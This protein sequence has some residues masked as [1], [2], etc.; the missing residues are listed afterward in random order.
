M[1]Y[2]PHRAD[3]ESQDFHVVQLAMSHSRFWPTVPRHLPSRGKGEVGK[4]V[5]A[6][7]VQR[8]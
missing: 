4:L 6:E 5:A 2:C 3:F 7:H 1:Q 8:A